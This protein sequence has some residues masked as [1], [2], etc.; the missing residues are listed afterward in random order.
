[1]RT[2]HEPNDAVSASDPLPKGLPTTEHMLCPKYCTP[3][4]A[5]FCHPHPTT[6]RHRPRHRAESLSRLLY[7]ERRPLSYTSFTAEKIDQGDHPPDEWGTHFRPCPRTGFGRMCGMSR[8]RTPTAP[9][10]SNRQ[11]VAIDRPLGPWWRRSCIRFRWTPFILRRR[12]LAGVSGSLGPA[13]RRRSCQRDSE[14]CR[15]RLRIDFC[16]GLSLRHA[17]SDQRSSCCASRIKYRTP[18]RLAR[19]AVHGSRRGA[20][21]GA[22]G[23]VTQISTTT[24]LHQCTFSCPLRSAPLHPSPCQTDAK[25]GGDSLRRRRIR[26]G[27]GFT[28]RC[29]CMVTDA[30]TRLGLPVALTAHPSDY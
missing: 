14:A 4:Q 25:E 21:Q 26:T 18:R 22:F 1:M 5:A 16:A 20:G 3:R 29:P 24:D 15:A 7:G 17:G 23:H 28:G 6:A 10:W 9:R 2:A 8:V 12:R 30:W 19:W 27:H 13:R 11:K